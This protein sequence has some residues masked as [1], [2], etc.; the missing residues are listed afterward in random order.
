MQ[1]YSIY[2][3]SFF[4][5]V[6]I[7][8]YTFAPK[9]R[10]YVLFLGSLCFALSFNLLTLLVLLCSAFLFF[11]LGKVIG[12]KHSN[13]IYLLTFVYVLTAFLLF[14]YFYAFSDNQILGLSIYNS[15]SFLKPVYVASIGLSF[16]LFQCI[17]Y[18][19][20][21]SRQNIKP[22]N[23]FI[24]FFNYLAF[25]PKFIAGPIERP[26]KFLTQLNY[27]S[28][29]D[30]KKVTDGM[31][32]LAW[33][34]FQKFILADNL[35]KVVDAVY[36]NS[37]QFPGFIILISIFLFSV[38]IFADFSG[39]TYIAIGISQM[40]GISLSENFRQ[41]YFAPSLREFWNRWHI[42]LSNW[43]R[44]Y[45][46]LPVAYKLNRLLKNDNVTYSVSIMISMILIGFWHGIG[47]TYIIWG[48]LHGLLLSLSF[49]TKKW[50]NKIMQKIGYNRTSKFHNFLRVFLTFIV[51][52]FL[53]IFFR[54]E[55]L[56]VVFSFFRG[57]TDNWIIDVYSFPK[58]KNYLSLFGL[59]RL[60]IAVIIIG[61]LLFAGFEIFQSR[62]KILNSIDRLNVVFR[63]TIYYVLFFSVLFLGSLNKIQNF[64][65]QQF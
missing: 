17:S 35:K 26:K 16:Y 4:A 21:I 50:R 39:Y 22:E 55:S 18:L 12:G 7:A 3:V 63:W 48:A 10:K 65:Y 42:T 30:Y 54:A 19:I 11:Y 53:W 20:E 13:M 59:S 37:D 9:Y 52:S 15:N 47:W 33:G 5:S 8:N 32:I 1:F 57:L 27:P 45:V 64:I 2:F 38:E 34:I 29:F 58:L 46:F 23:N 44:D 36:Y 14:R 41:P 40:L 6:F 49:I 28:D 24:N 51:V 25:F 43:I 56:N 31:K 62:A 61:T 60:D